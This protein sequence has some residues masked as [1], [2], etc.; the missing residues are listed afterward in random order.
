ME[1][2]SDKMRERLE[3]W[4]QNTTPVASAAKVRG[5]PR[6]YVAR[7][8]YGDEYEEEALLQEQRNRSNNGTSVGGKTAS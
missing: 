7:K 6:P 5:N 4:R 8:E 1:A 2:L 3:K